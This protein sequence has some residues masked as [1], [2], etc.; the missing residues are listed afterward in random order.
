MRTNMLQKNKAEMDEIE[1]SLHE[2]QLALTTKLYER[3]AAK[4]QRE[5]ERER[6]R[7]R[8]RERDGQLALTT[9][10]KG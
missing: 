6:E 7:A 8:D 4:V 3:L 10:L 2:G 9:K 5:G 1:A